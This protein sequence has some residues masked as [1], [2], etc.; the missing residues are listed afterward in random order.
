[1][2]KS[3]YRVFLTPI[4]LASKLIYTDNYDTYLP[5]GAPKA[6]HYHNLCEVGVCRE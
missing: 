1:M 4:D 3:S 2:Q 5:V 6:L